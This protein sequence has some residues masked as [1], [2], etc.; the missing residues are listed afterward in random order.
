MPLLVDP[1]V[2]CDGRCVLCFCRHIIPH[3]TRTHA[4]TPPLPS[5]SS[6]PAFLPLPVILTRSFLFR[7]SRPLS[8]WYLSV[9]IQRHLFRYNWLAANSTE[10]ASFCRY[11]SQKKKKKK[12]KNTFFFIYVNCQFPH[13]LRCTITLTVL[14]V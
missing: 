1:P 13:S 8:L 9:F 6:T 4:F 14:H 5:S 3:G 12:K 10:D 2:E 7:V 11:L